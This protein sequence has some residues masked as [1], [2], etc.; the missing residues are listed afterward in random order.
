MAIALRVPTILRA[1]PACYALAFLLMLATGCKQTERVPLSYDPPG[2]TVT[3]DKEITRQARGATV[4]EAAGVGFDNRFEGA[5][6]S[7][8]EQLDDSTYRI[9]L[10]PENAPINNS[11][12]YAFKVWA[13]RAQTIRVRLVYADGTHR[14]VPKLSR[15]GESWRRVEAPAYQPDPVRGTAALQLDV[16][17]DTL[18]VAAQELVTSSDME[19]WTQE[20][21]GRP[22]VT[23][24]VVGRSAR[25]QP[26]TMLEITEAGPEA[27]VVLVIGRQHPPEVTGTLAAQAYLE[28]LAAEGTLA[29]RFRDRFRV[30]A[31]PLVNPDGVDA[32]HWRHN[33]HGVDLNRD[34]DA[35]NQPETRA[36]RDAFLALRDDP[37]LTVRFALD[38]HSTQRD[39]FYT[40]SR[41]LVTDPPGFI[42]AW[43]DAIREALP[44]YEV[45]DDPS[46]LGSPVSKNW[47]Y[48]E[49]GVP[50][51]TYEVGDT[52][53]RGRIRA[54]AEAAAEATMRLLLEANE[55][56]AQ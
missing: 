55:E 13:D 20:L 26:L 47:F 25:G 56:A 30:V 17:P 15:D 6:L 50:S 12:W 34:W 37:Q 18:W 1:G 36:V 41:D 14:Y 8:V 3:T 9:A 31:V 22:W 38:F 49:F 16:G 54:V 29:Q 21:A 24:S 53:D 10:R 28:A 23:R 33:A 46:G 43:L 2:A 45:V 5:R 35:F 19:A 7:A 11:A 52:T 51:V 40:L 44:D 27:G 32:G 4:F 48:E 42:D 39:V